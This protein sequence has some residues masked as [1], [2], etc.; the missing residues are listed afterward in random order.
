MAAA[1]CQCHALEPPSLKPSLGMLLVTFLRLYGSKGLDTRVHGVSLCNYQPQPQQQQQQQIQHQHQHHHYHHN[2]HPMAVST[3]TST[4]TPIMTRSS[5]LTPLH[6]PGSFLTPR[7]GSAGYWAP[8]PPVV[9]VDPLNPANNVGRTCFGFRQVQLCFDDALASID[10]SFDAAR[11]QQHHHQHHPH[12]P[13]QRF[14]PPAAHA[15]VAA[16]H[17]HANAAFAAAGKKQ[18]SVL[19]AVFGAAH[20]QQ[21]VNLSASVWCPFEQRARSSNGRH[22]KVPQSPPQQPPQQPQPTWKLGSGRG[23]FSTMSAM[24][25]TAAAAETAAAAPPASSFWVSSLTESEQ[26]ELRALMGSAT[27]LDYRQAQRVRWLLQQTA[28]RKE[29][30][31]E[32]A[33]EEEEEEEEEE[34]GEGGGERETDDEKGGGLDCRIVDKSCAEPVDESGQGEKELSSISNEELRALCMSKIKDTKRGTLERLYRLLTTAEH[35][36]A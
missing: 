16:I 20:H 10:R 13:H 21:V 12:H 6:A 36:A 32:G 18:R 11:Q 3:I 9:I 22:N 33:G 7:V 30:R 29:D 1:V 23:L 24:T 25:T 31:G 8:P 5:P 35:G 14:A 19:G 15:N 28:V 34:E 27:P 4:M 17:P 2:N 26:R